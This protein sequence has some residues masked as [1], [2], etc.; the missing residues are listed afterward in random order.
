MRVTENPQTEKNLLD[1]LALEVH[2]PLP[3]SPAL[4]WLRLF[5]DMYH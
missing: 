1:F 3:G 5:L 4:P 2:L